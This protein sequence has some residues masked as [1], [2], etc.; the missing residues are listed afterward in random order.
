VVTVV[1]VVDDEV[2]APPVGG[3]DVSDVVDGVVVVV[4]VGGAELLV[5]TDEGDPVRVAVLVGVGLLVAL[6]A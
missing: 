4:V 1:P 3:D 5:A 6:G 2:D